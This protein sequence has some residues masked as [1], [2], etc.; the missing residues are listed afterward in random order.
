MDAAR[1]APDGRTIVFGA[2]WEGKPSEIFSTQPGSPEARS[3]DLPDAV[4]LGVSSSG[5][6]AV[7]VR[8]PPQPGRTLARVPLGGGAPREVLENVD[9]ADWGPD[10][11]SLLVL[12]RSG[13]RVTIELPI[14]KVLYEAA[15][16]Q[17]ARVSPQGDR[18]AFTEH[19]FVGDH[20]GDVGVVDRAGKKTTLAA[21]WEDLGGLAWSPDGREVWF[22]GSMAGADR[23]LYAVTLS[24]QQRLVARVPGNLVLQ[25]IAPDG[26]VLVSHGMVR[27]ITLALAPGEAKERDLT[28]LDFSIAADLSADG[29]T[30]LFSEQGVA[31]G[32]QYAVYARGTDGGPAVRLGKGNAQALSPDG[33]WALALDL[34]PPH[35]L[36]L[37]PTGPGESRH[38]PRHS[39]T[40]FQG[41]VFMPDGKAVLVVGAEPGRAPRSY[42][43][44]LA[45]GPPRPIT[46]EGV[47]VFGNGI[48][49]DGRFV[50][51]STG[52]ESRIYPLD[53]GEPRPIPGLR[54]GELPLR[55]ASDGTLY[56]R[57]P[58]GVGGL[59]M[60]IDRLDIAT[61][62]RQPWKELAPADLA[63]VTG[64]ITIILTPDARSYAYTYISRLSNL[65][66]VEGLK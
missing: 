55:W 53:G 61:G 15:V 16:I 52:T 44:D 42:I 4:L 64:V 49:P 40:S 26:R 57:P 10:G 27:P 50:A 5:E 46:P 43:Q 38:L 25:D 22:A 47:F 59:P 13:P 56:V 62:R 60:K 41:A 19:P 7:G 17:S 65:Y 2:R 58:F 30:L 9:G 29:K 54:P 28:W 36:V 66:L 14:G 11:S 45:G 31:G 39:I 18:V 12:R 20:R 32:P 8:R 23:H 6:M 21:G 63:G 48:S 24:G 3:F 37:L 35:H 1:F 34:T 51:G 33:Q